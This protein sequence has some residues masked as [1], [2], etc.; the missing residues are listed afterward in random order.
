MHQK[1][2]CQNMDFETVGRNGSVTWTSHFDICH[3][4]HWSMFQ[5]AKQS[6]TDFY[7]TV[8]ALF[9]SL[10]LFANQLDRSQ[11][12]GTGP[13]KEICV[14]PAQIC[15]KLTEIRQKL[16]EKHVNTP[17]NKPGLVLSK[18]TLLWGPV[19]ALPGN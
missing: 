1:I 4:I 10:I 15:W 7:P 18:Q 8:T 2:F 17:K 6:K 3:P 12:Q 11:N 13:I 14:N 9:N 16:A 19:L 5:L